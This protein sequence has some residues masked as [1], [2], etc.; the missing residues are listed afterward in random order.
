MSRDYATTMVQWN[1]LPLMRYRVLEADE[2]FGLS[3]GDIVLWKLYS[4]VQE[5]RSY[6]YSLP[7][8][9]DL[10]VDVRGPRWAW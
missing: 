6:P 3:V 9:D 5:W 1:G 7:Y 2:R 10:D 4:A 8:T